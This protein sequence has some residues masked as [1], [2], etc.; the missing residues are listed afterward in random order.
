MTEHAGNITFYRSNVSFLLSRNLMNTI[1]Y[2]ADPLTIIL[3]LSFSN[4]TI[5]RRPGLS[6]GIKRSNVMQ[7]LK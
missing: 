4:C 2:S 3:M 6:P 7:D 1:I 5:T